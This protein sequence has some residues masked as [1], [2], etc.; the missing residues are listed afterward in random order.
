MGETWKDSSVGPDQSQKKKE[1]IDE[2]RTKGA[3]VHFASLMDICHLKNAELEAKHQ[4]C[5][6]RVVFRGDIVKGYSGSYVAFTEQW[7]SAS[8]MTAAK[9]MDIISRLPGCA[10][11]SAD[12][13]SFYTQVKSEDAPKLL[14]IPKSECP[15]WIRL[16]RHKSLESWSSMEDPVILLERNLY[17]H[18]LAGLLWERQLEKILLK[19]G[20]EKVSNCECLFV[21]C[22]KRI[23]LISV[24]GW[25]QIG[26]KKQNIDPMWRA[27]N[28]VVDLGEPTSFPD[29]VHLGCTQRQCEISKDIVDKHREFPQE[30][31]KNYR[32][33]KICVSLRGPTIWKVMPRNVWNDI[34]IW[35]TGRL[36]DSL[37]SI[38]STHWW[39][40]FQRRIE[41][42]GRID[43]VCSQ[44]VLHDRSQ[45][46]PKHVT[47]Y[48]VVWSLTFIIHVNTNSS[49]MWETL[50]NKADWGQFQDSDFAGDLEDSKSTS[51]G[52]LFLEVIH[53]FQTVGCVRN[54]LQFR[55]VQQNQKSFL[56]MQDWGWMVHDLWDLIVAVLGNTNQSHKEQGDPF[57]NKREVRSTNHT[58]QKTKTILKEW[59]MNWTMLI[60]FFQT[61]TLLI[62]KVCCMCVDATKQWSMWL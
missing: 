43:K 37:Q 60:L 23:I 17:G 49:A 53:L 57:M 10:G 36:N 44:I 31:L 19:Y 40:S 9:V 2:A 35:Q 30:Q 50:P 6:G 62:K 16:P 45:N 59:S 25:Q 58:I 20:W 56:W 27:L 29:H 5:K 52:T 41:I 32:A 48:Y 14:K 38:N 1:V 54:K 11:Q 33:R 46:G 7:S 51:G 18:L 15:E 47:K 12:A 39:P 22:E 61:S 13:V 28:K 55:T 34:E 8:Q 3:K 4:K 42:R 26:W 24:C 21:H